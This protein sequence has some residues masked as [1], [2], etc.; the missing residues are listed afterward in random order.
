MK[1]IIKFILFLM[2]FFSF[3]AKS[4]SG[5]LGSTFNVSASMDASPFF[6]NVVLPYRNMTYTKVKVLDTTFNSV[7]FNKLAFRSQFNVDINKVFSDKIQLG[8]QYSYQKFSMAGQKIVFTDTNYYNYQDLNSTLLS[9]I[10]IVNN[11]FTFRFKMFHQGLAPIGKYW[12]IDLNYSIAKSNSTIPIVHGFVKEGYSRSIFKVKKDINQFNPIYYD[13][14]N[15]QGIVKAFN[16]K[17]VYGRTI[18]ITEKLGLDFSMVVPLL[19]IHFLGLGAQF[20]K[21]NDPYLDL[22]N[23]YPNNFNNIISNYLRA[24]QKLMFNFGVRYFI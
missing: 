16:I 2:L 5:F 23:K 3:N 20:S 22:D 9:S 1:S 4:Q 14:L 17:F 13:T 12:G 6:T 18:P 19:K 21:V 7:E 11:S 15:Y 24:N 10:P 8:F